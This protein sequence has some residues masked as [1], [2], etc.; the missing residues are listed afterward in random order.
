[1]WD[2]IESL[3]GEDDFVDLSSSKKEEVTFGSIQS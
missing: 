1:M 2:K 3:G